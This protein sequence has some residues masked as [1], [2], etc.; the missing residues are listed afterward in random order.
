MKI[1][2]NQFV[3]EVTRRCNLACDHCARG[4]A[5]DIDLQPMYIDEIWGKVD[6]LE[7]EYKNA[8]RLGGGFY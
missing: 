7:F 6:L 1:N 2:T 5:Q 4:E 3:I 8:K